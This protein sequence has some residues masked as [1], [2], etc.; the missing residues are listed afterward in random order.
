MIKTIIF[1][2]YTQLFNTQRL[3][4]I[5]NPPTKIFNTKSS[6]FLN[7][8][9]L[10]MFNNPNQIQHKNTKTHLLNKILTP[11]KCNQF[12]KKIPQSEFPLV[13]CC[14]TVSDD[15]FFLVL[16]PP[17]AFA[18]LNE[19]HVFSSLKVTTFHAIIS[20]YEICKI[21]GVE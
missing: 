14:S 15:D 3:Q 6:V 8:I 19:P 7:Q 21:Y 17:K 12:I 20:E 4:F 5:K 16:N 10:Q 18:N 11:K 2:I 13:L 1:P 9:K